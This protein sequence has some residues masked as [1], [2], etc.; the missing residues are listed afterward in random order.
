M[1]GALGCRRNEA[2]AQ[3]TPAASASAEASSKA[4]RPRSKPIDS[5][6]P[7][8]P[9]IQQYKGIPAAPD[10]IAAIV[11]PSKL[12]V[13]DGP[14]GA[15]VGKVTVK[16]DPAPLRVGPQPP[17]ARC[18]KEGV[19]LNERMFRV[20]PGGELADAVIGVTEYGAYIPSRS[21]SVEVTIKNCTLSHRTVVATYGQRIDVKNLDVRESYLP[22]LDGAR[23]PALMVAMPQGGAVHLYPPSP[24]PFVLM[25]DLKHPWMAA[26]VLVFKYATF[27]VSA[28]DGSYKVEGL[29]AGKMKISLRHPQIPQTIEKELVIEASKTTEV[30][31]ELTY[32]APLPAASASGKPSGKQPVGKLPAG[33]QPEIH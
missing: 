22:H 25:D 33:K 3:D 18:G 5:S 13:Y 24:G 7:A 4:P 29:P 23:S 1:V 2:A 17:E 11:N 12:P 16:G 15:V 27:D 26:Q 28:L 9:V 8:T 14:M 21:E 19:A 10:E 6:N 32:Q 31:F 20:G 30:N